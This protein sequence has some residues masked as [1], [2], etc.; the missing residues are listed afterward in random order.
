[1]RKQASYRLGACGARS[2]ARIGAL[3]TLAVAATGVAEAQQS[4]TAPPAAAAPAAQS[5]SLTWKGITLYGIVDIGI[6]Y[7]THSAP[8]SD[9]FPAVTGA[10]VQKNDYDSPVGLSSNNL[11]QSRIGLSG[12][13]PLWGDWAGVFR[14]ETF[15]NPH[16]GDISDALKSVA[17]NNGKALNTQTIG[18]DSSVAGQLFGGAAYLGV[19]SPRFGSFT[20]GRNVTIVADGIS[21]Y[22]PMGAAQA[23]SVI[24]YSGTAA[25]GGDTEDRRLDQSIK[26][27]GKYG[28]VHVGALYEFSSQP[29][30]ID[31][32][33]Q[34][35]FGVDLAGFSGDFYYFKKY[36]AISVSAL[37]NV[38]VAEITNACNDDVTSITATNP[39]PPGGKT[40]P[41]TARCYSLSNS[42]AGTIS[43]NK[44]Y[45]VMALYNF[46]AVLPVKVYAGYEHIAFDN[47]ANTLP[48]GT[49]IIGGYTLAAVNKQVGAGS[50]YENEKTLEVFWAGVKWN[51]TPDLELTGAYYGYKQNSFANGANTGCTT[52]KNSGCSGTENAG[53]LLADYRLGKRFD[54]YFGGMWSGVQDGLANG[55]INKDNIATTL[56]V[57]FKF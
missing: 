38:Q 8:F 24:G 21:K 19:A 28:P 2:A 55:Y 50:T 44:T 33:Y 7:D 32:G 22:D 3:L 41:S 54:V 49:V 46:G 52:V 26:Y 48:V 37:S 20:F 27:V 35:Q 47:P 5:D 36:D 18:V 57:R 30:S 43:D 11:S 40:T 25:G 1:V 14:L 56:G 16:S 17:L 45:S 10:L 12:N 6:Q 39:P 23:F 31:T 34:V 29:G 4:P 53:S 51:V 9:Y 13:E 42:V 15:F